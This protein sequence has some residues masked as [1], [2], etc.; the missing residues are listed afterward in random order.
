M[1]QVGGEREGRGKEGR[2]EGMSRKGRAIDWVE[3]VQINVQFVVIPCAI[4]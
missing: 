1:L 4:W 3:Q 2:G